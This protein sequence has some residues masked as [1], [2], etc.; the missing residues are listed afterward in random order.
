VSRT[1]VETE[2]V[3]GRPRLV[4]HDD[5]VERV[6]EALADLLVAAFE[7]VSVGDAK[8]TE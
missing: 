3:E 6:V 4:V 1:P 7:G 2:V 8:A 5:D